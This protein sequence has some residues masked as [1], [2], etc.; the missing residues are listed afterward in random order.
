MRADALVPPF[1]GARGPESKVAVVAFLLLTPLLSG[2][3]APQTAD[4]SAPP[5][6][7]RKDGRGDTGAFKQTDLWL[8]TTTDPN[9]NRGNHGIFLGNGSVGVTFGA[10]GAGD[11]TAAAYSAGAYDKNEVLQNIAPIITAPPQGSGTEYSQTLDMKRGVLL[12]KRG[13]ETITSFVAATLPGVVVVHRDKTR[14]DNKDNFTMAT[15]D[16]PAPVNRRIRATAL[17]EQPA[18]GLTVIAKVSEKSQTS[19]ESSNDIEAIPY[20]KLLSEQEAAWQ[21][22]WQDADIQIEGDPEAQQLVHKL[23]FDLLQSTRPGAT[24][25]IPPESL[26]GDFYNGHIFWDAEVWMFPALLAQHPNYARSILD[27]R[28]KHLAAAKAKAKAEGYAGADFPWESASSGKEV[29][30]SGFSKGR[31]VTAGVGWA[32]WQYWLATQDREW[33]KTRG[34]P[35]L[36]AVADFWASRA[37]KNAQ[38]G[39]WDVLDVYGPDENKGEADNNTYTNAMAR[40]CLLAAAEAA[41]IVG[42]PASPKWQTV[43]TNITL[44]FD[45]KGGYYLA[46]QND[47]GKATKQADGEL[48]IYPAALPMDRKTAEATFDVQSKRPIKN[49]PAMTDAMHAL[50]AA[51]LG[52][53]QEAEQAFRDS[54]R[55]FIRGPFLLFSEKRSLDRCV[56]TTGAGG[57]LQAVIYGFG[58]LDLSKP[59][60]II[61]GKP[62][63]PLSWKKLTITGIKRGGKRYTLTVTPEK[64]TLTM[65]Q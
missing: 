10:Q 63:L 58:G 25:S 64:R 24:D 32:H 53:A 23:M 36:S 46:R 35:V 54:Y 19:P 27:Y 33:L 9:A 8:L 37:K 31:H 34:W 7:T 6:Q 3:P 56:F 4:D 65:A 20:K 40:Y 39:K 48:V 15:K 16:V 13:D 60:G 55:P 59:S 42:Q 45:K 5:L 17:F 43:A 11:K 38:T 18:E 41:K 57:V 62:T 51:R 61:E 28:F 26:S 21:R 1:M 29:A 2:C 12:T 30:P 22:L 14:T 47:E 52:R 50:I 49:G 44:P